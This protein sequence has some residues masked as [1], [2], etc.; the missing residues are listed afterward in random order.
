MD[1]YHKE[2]KGGTNFWNFIFSDFFIFVL[3]GALWLM[4]ATRGGYLSAVSPFDAILMSLAAFRVTRL[5]VYDKI[6]KWFRD[7]F[8]GSTNGFMRTVEDLLNCPWCIG[9]WSALIIVV[10]YFIFPWAWS[11]I[12]FLAIAGA[13]SFMQIYANQVGWR[14]ENLKMSAKEKEAELNTEVDRTSIGN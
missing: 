10:C 4:K 13:G 11:V 6:S 14:A 2:R 5:V 7:L 1:T 12:L 9:F 3:I 8:A